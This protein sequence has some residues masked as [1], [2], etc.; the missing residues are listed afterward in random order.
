MRWSWQ[1]LVDIGRETA[2]RALAHDLGTLAGNLAFRL[3]LALFPFFIFV[4]ALSGFVAQGLGIANPA[5]QLV[6]TLGTALPSDVGKVLQEQLQPLFAARN[7]TLVVSATVATLVAASSA[8]LALFVACNL[9]YGVAESRPRWRRY[10]LAAV[11]SVLAGALLV[12]AFTL[13]IGGETLGA[14]LLHAIGVGS[15]WGAFVETAQWLVIALLVLLAVMALYRVAP[16]RHTRPAG[17]LPGAL[18]F[19]VVWI[20]VTQIFAFYLAHA[21]TFGA[22]YGALAGAVVLLIWFYLT[23]IVLL[24]GAELNAVVEQRAYP[25]RVAVERL[26]AQARAIAPDPSPVFDGQRGASSR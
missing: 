26:Q 9:T 18:L 19:L 21:V 4:A 20:V 24:V 8:F 11:L 16:N 7:P 17:I 15:A 10:G 14:H 23:S 3:F 12:V 22:T 25:T 5:Q 2:R 13:A 1:E 6:K